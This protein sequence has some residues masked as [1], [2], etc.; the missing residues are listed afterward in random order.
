MAL[1]ETL[2]NF[3]A[4]FA[5]ALA[6]L[7][8]FVSLYLRLTPYA[9][10]QLIRD[11]NLAAAYALLGTLLG[12]VLP[13]ASSIAHSV[14]LRDMLVWGSVAMLVQALVYLIVARLVPELK[15]GIAAN[16]VA[17]GVLLGG[18]AL[19]IGIINAACMVY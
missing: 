14:S 2:P 10:L 15:A 3:F 7:G 6:L 19:C 16:Q 13:L 4:Y 9:E 5:C 8:L 18:L 12:F 11:G 17:H 1:L